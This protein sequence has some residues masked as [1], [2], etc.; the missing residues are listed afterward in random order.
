MEARAGD[1]ILSSCTCLNNPILA[2]VVGRDVVDPWDMRTSGER[3]ML[4]SS[5]QFQLVLFPPQETQT[6]SAHT[7]CLGGPLPQKSDVL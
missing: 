7:Y 4:S 1:A 6:V 3:D 2:V 5:D